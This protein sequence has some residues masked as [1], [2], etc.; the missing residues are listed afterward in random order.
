MAVLQVSRARP[1]LPVCLRTDPRAL[2]PAT[3]SVTNGGTG[4]K[5][6]QEGEAVKQSEEIAEISTT[7]RGSA[8]GLGVVAWLKAVGLPGTSNANHI[9]FS[10]RQALERSL[11]PAVRRSLKVARATNSSGAN[12]LPTTSSAPSSNAAICR[13][14]RLSPVTIR[15][16]ISLP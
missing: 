5:N 14:L 15:M 6:N 8:H 13:S 2:L 7:D 3:S 11:L 4:G 9:R 12:G 16:A 10:I 1:A